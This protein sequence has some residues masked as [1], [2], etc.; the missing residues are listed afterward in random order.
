MTLLGSYRRFAP[1]V[2]GEGRRFALAGTLLVV[3]A[4][5]EVLAVFVLA[6]VIDG[7]LSARGLTDFARMASL[8]LL[9]TAVSTAADYGGQLVS[10]GISERVVLR[11]R[12]QLFAHV[13]TLHPVQLRRLGIGN[14][15]SRHT[16]D[17]EAVEYLIGTGAMQ[18][19][20][21]LAHVAGLMTAALLM[22]WQASLIAI[23]AVPALWV[24]SSIFARL[25]ASATHDERGANGHI[26]DSVEST[27]MGHET[28]IAYN[29]Q[30]R[31]HRTLHDHGVAWMRARLGQ[32]RVEAGFGAILGMGQLVVTLAIALA[33]LWQVREGNLTVGQLLAL[34][35]YLGML[36][37]KMQEIADVRLAV[38]S[39]LVSAERVAEVLD[40]RAVESDH[41]NAVDRIA[42]GPVGIALRH[43]SL[44]R[45]HRR[46]LDDVS[47]DLEPGT[48]TAL[49]GASGE[50]KSTLAS[51]LTRLEHPDSGEIWLGAVEYRMLTGTAIRN[52]VTLLPQQPVVRAATIADNIAYGRPGASRAEVVKAARAADV[53]TFVRS[54]PGGYD[55]VI[56]DGGLTLSG[57]QRQRIAMARA[58]LRDAPVLIL[59][60]PT[61]GLDAA[62]VDR[63]LRPLRCVA[64]GH[65]TLLIT[66]DARVAAMADRI[67]ELRGGR[68]H[69]LAVRRVPVV[70]EQSAG[71]RSRHGRHRVEM[72]P[73]PG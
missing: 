44:S 2:H 47:L 20:V 6:D 23:G 9:V 22:N 8:W 72:Q 3:A 4:A 17:L 43:V 34:T 5:C 35:G 26:A 21:A 68:L 24:L 28:T 33:G 30:G 55:T 18:F 62:A 37:P 64:G 54:L 42:S 59:D 16:G 13:Q 27:L 58:V 32:T 69:E 15:V 29:Q 12:D 14:L 11:L 45:G 25:Q 39:A 53:D 10:V 52:R 57:G 46:V 41:P 48:I 70:G 19:V 38:S 7:A 1:A 65:T 66:H 40:V 61:S 51:L 49:V 50:G 67:V 63:I 73:A 56:D 31:E 60:E 36:Y 71:A